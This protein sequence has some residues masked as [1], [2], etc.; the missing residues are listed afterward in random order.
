MQD[1]AGGTQLFNSSKL[2]YLIDA[3]PPIS[4][5]DSAHVW[6]NSSFVNTFI[7]HFWNTGTLSQNIQTDEPIY[8][9]SNSLVAK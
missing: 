3:V 9:M 4:A 1:T 2:I 8:W 7:S 6:E 5:P